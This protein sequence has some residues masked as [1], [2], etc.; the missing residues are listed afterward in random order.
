MVATGGE[1]NT[2]RHGTEESLGECHED[3]TPEVGRHPTYPVLT[4]TTYHPP[5]NNTEGPTELSSWAALGA[6]F[7]PP[8]ALEKVSA[9]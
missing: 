6:F 3:H 9:F 7:N 2:F 5:D 1:G 8:C 4:M